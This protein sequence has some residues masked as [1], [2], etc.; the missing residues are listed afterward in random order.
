[1]VV[2]VC[3]VTEGL[4]IRDCKTGINRLLDPKHRHWCFLD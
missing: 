1:M 3:T 4:K 2:T